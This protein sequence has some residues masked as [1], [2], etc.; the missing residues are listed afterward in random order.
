MPPTLA[1]RWTTTAAPS[2]ASRVADGSRRS[3]SA[4]RTTR[5]SAPSASSCRVT[6][7]P[8]KPAPPVTTTGLPVQNSRDGEA[9]AMPGI[10]G[11]A[12]DPGGHA[13]LREQVADAP[14]GAVGDPCPDHAELA[15]PQGVIE[16]HG[17]VGGEV[18][19]DRRK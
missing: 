19:A 11:R 17:R 4:E 15:V 12:D 5:T 6:A 7:V 1:A 3:W 8:R 2:T 10:L 13:A 18:A 14:H 16:Q 9:A